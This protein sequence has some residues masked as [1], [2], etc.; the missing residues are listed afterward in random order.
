MTASTPA[1][2]TQLHGSEL[3]RMRLAEWYLE[4]GS[5]PPAA[6]GKVAEIA[7][8]LMRQGPVNVWRHIGDGSLRP[9]LVSLGS[10]DPNEERV[11]TFRSKKQR[12]KR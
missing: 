12:G 5:E 10:R 11:A 9:R 4:N 3:I 2:P 7:F 8:E 6:L 1:G